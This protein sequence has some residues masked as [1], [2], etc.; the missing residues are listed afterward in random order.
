MSGARTPLRRFLI[1]LSILVVVLVSAAVIWFVRPKGVAAVALFQVQSSAPSLFEDQAV[2]PSIDRDFEI[3]KKTQIALL[4]SKFVL[5]SALVNPG[6]ASL[7]VFAG[8]DD[9]ELWLK[10]NLEI[11]YPQDGEILQI[12]LRGSK[13]QAPELEVIV[14][15]VASAYEKEVLGN[16]KARR[17]VQ[18]DMMER[19]LQNLTS[20]IK[21]KMEDYLDIAKGMARPDANSNDFQQQRL[22]KQLDRVDDELTQ[23]EREQLR[24][25]TGGDDKESKFLKQRMEQLRTRQDELL[26]NLER[27]SQRSVDLETRKEELKQLQTIANDLSVKLEKMDIEAAAPARI[28]KIQPAVIEPAQVASQ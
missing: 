5:S 18:R 4:K 15:A 23:L 1:A 6:V 24:I 7:S 21:R 20:E 9:P 16:E 28:L 8:K 17:L 3:L 14:N 27:R 26:K 22:V 11:D 12:K 13:S 2:R 10:D 25:A 19:S